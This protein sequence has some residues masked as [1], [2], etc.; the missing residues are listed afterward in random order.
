[1]AAETALLRTNELPAK[2]ASKTGPQG[3]APILMQAL[4]PFYIVLQIST[5]L[6]FDKIKQ[7][8]SSSVHLIFI[9][10]ASDDQ[11]KQINCTN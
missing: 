6:A 1:M 8:H 4:S 9:I 7:V 5:A 3:T 10:L 2:R 11:T